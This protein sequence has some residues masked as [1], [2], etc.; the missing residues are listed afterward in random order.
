[1]VIDDME[2][3]AGEIGEVNGRGKKKE[4]IVDEEHVEERKENEPMEI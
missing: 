2:S 4:V 3:G 1:M